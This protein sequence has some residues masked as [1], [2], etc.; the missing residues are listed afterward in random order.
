M[1]PTRNS[2][3]DPSVLGA[4]SSRKVWWLCAACGR[5]WQARVAD[6]TAGDRCPNCSRRARAHMRSAASEDQKSARQS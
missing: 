3:L 1:H 5:E 4:R 2:D 6:R